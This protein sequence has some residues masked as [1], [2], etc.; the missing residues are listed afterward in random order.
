LY[1]F[2]QKDDQFASKIISLRINDLAFSATKENSN[3][4]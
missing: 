1:S 3:N 2:T 4:L